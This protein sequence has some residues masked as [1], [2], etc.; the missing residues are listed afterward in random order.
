MTLFEQYPP[1]DGRPTR[2]YRPCCE[3]ERYPPGWPRRV[4]QFLHQFAHSRVPFTADGL[5]V[6]AG[7]APEIASLA[8]EKAEH[9]EKWIVRVRP[10][11]YMHETPAL[12][13]GAL[14]RK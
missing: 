3:L 14:P 7:A 9:D 5:A 13:V 8:I 6:V 10:E 1:T 11:P 2:P 4:W 12:W